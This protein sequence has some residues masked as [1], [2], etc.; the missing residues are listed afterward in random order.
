MGGVGWGGGLEI[1]IILVVYTS[2]RMIRVLM[3][4]CALFFAVSSFWGNKY[5]REVGKVG[6]VALINQLIERKEGNSSKHLRLFTYHNE[7]MRCSE[8]KFQSNSYRIYI[9]KRM[10]RNVYEEDS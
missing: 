3:F 4:Q 8:F 2:V 7:S 1:H 5:V 9:Y 6:K 10:Q